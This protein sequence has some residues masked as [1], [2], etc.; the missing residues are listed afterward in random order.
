MTGPSIELGTPCS[1]KQEGSGT[2][3][4][5]VYRRPRRRWRRLLLEQKVPKGCNVMLKLT[6]ILQR[7][8]LGLI[9][10]LTTSVARSAG[11]RTAARDIPRSAYNEPR[12]H[13][14][15]AIAPKTRTLE[16]KFWPAVSGTNREERRGSRSNNIDD[17]FEVGTSI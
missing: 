5:R 14:H 7:T 17:D 8:I 15:N 12:R 6:G 11:S 13:Y 10:G 16:A 4:M 1:E 3:R 2:V 9:F